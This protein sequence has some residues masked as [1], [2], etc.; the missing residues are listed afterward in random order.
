MMRSRRAGLGKMRWLCAHAPSELLHT[1]MSSIWTILISRFKVP[2]TLFILI[3]EITYNN[4]VDSHTAFQ[5][6]QALAHLEH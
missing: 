1:C 2:V 4:H 5:T 6:E 3:L